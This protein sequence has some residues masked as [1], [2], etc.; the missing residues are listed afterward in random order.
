MHEGCAP[1]NARSFIL[2]MVS[3]GRIADHGFLGNSLFSFASLL[4]LRCAA[5]LKICRASLAFGP[6]LIAQM[7]ADHARLFHSRPFL[8]PSWPKTVRAMALGANWGRE[9]G[10]ELGARTGGDDWRKDCGYGAECSKSPTGRA[11][12]GPA[13]QTGLMGKT[14]A[15]T[16]IDLNPK[17]PMGRAADHP[18]VFPP[19]R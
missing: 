18:M 13:A 1:P 4:R 14:P 5:P 17:A 16:D 2:T 12:R 3:K 9:L 7:P 6:S 19:I 11:G 8:A 15:R 10:A